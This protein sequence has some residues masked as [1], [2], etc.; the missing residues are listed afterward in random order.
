MHSKLL[1]SST[2]MVPL[3][4]LPDIQTIVSRALGGIVPTP[5]RYLENLKVYQPTTGRLIWDVVNSPAGICIV[6]EGQVRLVDEDD[7]LVLS[8]PVGASF[9]SASLFPNRRFQFYAARASHNLKLC[10]LNLA[11]LQPLFEQYPALRAYQYQQAID[12]DLRLLCHG[13]PMTDNNLSGAALLRLP[14]LIDCVYQASGTLSD[15]TQIDRQLWILRRGELLH[16]AGQRLSAGQVY[17]DSQLPSNGSWQVIQPIEMY[18]LSKTAYQQLRHV[19]SSRGSRAVRPPAIVGSPQLGSEPG[20]EAGV[21]Q[22]DIGDYD[23]DLADDLLSPR[24]PDSSASKPYFPRPTVRLGQWWQQLTEQYPFFKQ[25]SSSDC[26]IACLVMVGLYWGK[27]LNLPQLRT[28]ANVDRSGSS[29]AG[30]V[31]AA[32]SVGLAPRPVKIDLQ[33]LARQPL[34]AIAHWK[35]KHYV[36]VYRVTPQKVM[37]SDPAVGRCRLTHAEFQKGWTGYTLLLQPTSV[38]HVTQEAK[39]DLWRFFEVIKP[40]RLVLSEVLVASIMIEIFGLSIPVFTQ[41]LLDRVVVQRSLPTFF[42]VGSGLLIFSLF[43]ACM[44]SLRRYLLFH[45]TNRIDLSLVAGFINHTFR[46]PLQF[47]DTR[48][49]GDIT[50]RVQENIKIRDFLSGDALTT[51]L[52]LLTVV[53]YLGLMI[54]YSWQMTLMAVVLVPLLV[55]LTLVVTPF[56]R[57]I[58]REIFNAKTAEGRYLIEALSGI[59]TVKMMG[60]ERTVRWRWEDL[61]S[62]S[63]KISFSGQVFREQFALLSAIIEIVTMNL[64][65]LFGVWQVIHGQL[66]I[67]QLVAFN[68][69]LTS[70]ISPF[71][72]LAY[73]W[74]DFQD[75]LISLERINDVIDAKPEE[76]RQ[77]NLPELQ[78]LRGQVRFEQVTFRYSTE[79]A[80][81]TL[82]NLSFEIFPGQTV[83]VVGRSGSGKTTLAKLMLG[84]YTPTHGKVWIDGFDV[85][86][87]AKQPLRRRI[88]VVDQNT[89][90]FGGTIRENIS[91]AYPNASMEE[92][93]AAATLAG[94]HSF[95]DEFPLKYETPIGEGGGLLSGGQR[96]RLAIARALL[97]DPKLLILDEATSSLD[98]ESERLIQ[99]NLASIAHNRTML[100]IAH[101]LSTVRSADL[102]LVIDKGVLVESGTHDQLI[103]QRGQYF[104][105]NQQQLAIAS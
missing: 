88:G 104:Y 64:V 61:F 55:L 32:E 102:I 21:E 36:V 97:G 80:S 1:Y 71:K 74:N 31:N 67:G 86:T 72:R 24:T 26:G 53:V 9:G 25:Q 45:T 77:S 27:R 49:V 81:N 59:G 20:A 22:P 29:L 51:L 42:A 2:P 57:R 46:L 38:F 28:I 35:G 92:I 40:H 39:P 89:F 10:V 30:L 68:I 6:L 96:Q 34:P 99:T 60:I 19:P 54:W 52:D 87:I 98:A 90:L 91:I 103:A 14:E 37:I 3:A 16:A 73:L 50:S 8:L 41:L 78:A 75:V 69:L 5:N 84:L 17:F 76:A 18:C 70:V 4:S 7:E 33:G 58:A 23:R 44:N 79:S 13:S 43:S 94:A 83:A 93:I 11:L 66:S 15:S 95:I 101:R 65:F 105:L 48:F 100:I 56:L 12:T 62:Q 47:F 63:I 85:S 82:E